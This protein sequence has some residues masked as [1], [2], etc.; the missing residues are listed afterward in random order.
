MRII[1]FDQRN[2]PAAFP[3]LQG[4]LPLNGLISTAVHFEIY[5]GFHNVPLGETV[6]QPFPVLVNASYQIAGYA[7]VEGAFLPAGQD[8]NVMGHGKA[9]GAVMDP[10][11]KHGDE[12]K[13]NGDDRRARSSD[14]RGFANGGSSLVRR[15]YCM[16]GSAVARYLLE[17]GTAPRHPRLPFPQTQASIPSLILYSF[18]HARA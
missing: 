10:R 13:G 12:G 2:F 9:S 16:V 8:V 17:P 3:M 1:A 18:P 11:V 6:R 14:E 5:K 7:D 4:F 15:G